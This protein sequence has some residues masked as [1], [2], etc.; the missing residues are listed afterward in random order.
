MSSYIPYLQ[1]RVKWN[2]TKRNLSVGDLVLICDVSYPRGVWPLGLI[3][4]VNTSRDGL[5]RS[6]RIR[7]AKT[8]LVRPV[9]NVVL[10]EGACDS[11][12]SDY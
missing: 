4:E 10:L 12:S 6:V 9:T 11:E 1:K 8:E 3:E 7:T 5:V 2:V